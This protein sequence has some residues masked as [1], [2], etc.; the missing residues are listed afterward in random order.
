M[1]NRIIDVFIKVKNKK[2][3]SVKKYEDLHSVSS[4]PGILHGCVNFYKPKIYKAVK[5]SVPPFRPIL[6]AL[7][8]PTYELSK[9]LVPLSTTLTLN[10]YKIKDLFSFAEELLN[11]GS[12]LIMASF[13]FEPLFTNMPLRES[14][15]LSVELLFNDKSNI[16][17]FTII[18]FL[19][20]LTVNMFESLL[21]F[22]DEYYEQINGVAMGFPIR[23]NFSHYFSQLN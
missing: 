8:P 9:F 22:D 19:K 23:S 21:L 5:D 15:D 17:G 11:S 12:D 1:E 10:E 18:D 16:D 6:S 3:I 20:L 2:I 7:C 14:I 13:D 4:G